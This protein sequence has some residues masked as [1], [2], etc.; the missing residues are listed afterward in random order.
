MLLPG[1]FPPKKGGIA[2]WM[3]NIAKYLGKKYS[4]TVLSSFQFPEHSGEF[5]HVFLNISEKYRFYDYCKALI[6]FVKYLLC[7]KKWYQEPKSSALSF[8]LFRVYYKYLL[9]GFL[10]L[11]EAIRIVETKSINVILVGRIAPE[12]ILALTLK[13]LF[14][15]HYT[16][17]VHGKLFLKLLKHPKDKTVAFKVLENAETIIVN[18]SYTAQLLSAAKVNCKRITILHPG[19]DTEYFKPN[20]DI[21]SLSDELGIQNHK[22]LLTVSNL[23]HRKG[24][25]L[26]IKAVRQLLDEGLKVKYLIIGN[27]ENYNNLKKL[28]VDLRVESSVMFVERVDDNA[29]PYYY[30]LCDVF[31]MPSLKIDHNVE[32]FGITFIEAN[33]C[34]KPVIG[35]K[36]GGISDAILDNETGLL[37]S[38][39]D[40]EELKNAILRLFSNKDLYS[41]L[42][43]A[44]R[45]R[46]ERFFDWSVLMEKLESIIL[47]NR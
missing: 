24:H 28:C 13:W 34:G 30:N 35:S 20:L 43:Q 16:V 45:L 32:G 41:K 39:G 9:Y 14:G 7:K 19:T 27:G 29:L 31:I 8:Y 42:S 46:A 12:G 3:Y 25:E 21:K 10:M 47:L 23:D 6:H 11:A 4:V 22:V 40:G 18:S 2:T 44:G 5:N 38:P 36:S 26:V 15:I 1:N 33:A 37:I 17:F